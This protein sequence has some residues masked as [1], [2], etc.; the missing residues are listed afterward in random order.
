MTSAPSGS[1]VND[2]TLDTIA[3]YGYNSGPTKGSTTN[4][5]VHEVG[6]KAPNSVG[7]Y[8]VSGNLYGWCL[9]WYQS[10]TYTGGTD[11]VSAASGASDRVLRGGSWNDN[12][13]GCSL[14]GRGSTGPGA[15]RYSFGF[16]VA[17]VP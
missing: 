3:W 15:L 10:G 11:G 7:L 16:R 2:A 5:H 1:N 6:K 14:G 8:D 9:D 13:T 12:P 4:S 17:V